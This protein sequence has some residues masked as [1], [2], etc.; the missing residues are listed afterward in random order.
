MMS[1]SLN[2]GSMMGRR[3]SS[4]KVGLSEFAQ[5]LVFIADS[6]GS[7]TDTNASVAPYESILGNPSMR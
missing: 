6:P 2:M 4:L 7:L 5:T 1:L 3:S